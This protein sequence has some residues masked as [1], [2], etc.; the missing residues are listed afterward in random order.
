MTTDHYNRGET[1][2]LWSNATDGWGD[3]Y[4]TWVTVSGERYTFL[5]LHFQSQVIN[6]THIKNLKKKWWSW[7]YTNTVIRKQLVQLQRETISRKPYPFY[8]SQ[9]TSCHLKTLSNSREIWCDSGTWACAF[10]PPAQL[11]NIQMSHSAHMETNNMIQNPPM[12]HLQSWTWHTHTH[13]RSRC[14]LGFLMPNRVWAETYNK[15]SWSNPSPL[16]HRRRLLSPQ[17]QAEWTN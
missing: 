9:T 8:Q 1:E 12:S 4:V 2:E 15:H 17:E 5:L 10:G 6:L 14:P 11:P 3:N 16:A 13:T 7:F